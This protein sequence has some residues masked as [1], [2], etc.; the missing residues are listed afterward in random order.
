M[1]HTKH[2]I[3]PFFLYA[4]NIF[5]ENTPKLVVSETGNNLAALDSSTTDW[6]PVRILKYSS[7]YSLHL[8]N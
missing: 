1:K 6:S 5:E 2:K 7:D 4:P 8:A 3:M